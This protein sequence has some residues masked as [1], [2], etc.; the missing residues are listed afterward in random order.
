M[1]S[2][3]NDEYIIKVKSI[4]GSKYDYSKTV[5]VYCRKKVKIICKKHGLFLQTPTNH[6][7]GQGCPKCRKYRIKNDKI[8]KDYCKL[9]NITILEIKYTDFDKIE[10]TISNSLNII[11]T[12]IHCK[13]N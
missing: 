2:L 7:H 9:N 6:L 5:Y 1:K 12:N 3:T 8:K 10:E 13:R 4:H 11:N